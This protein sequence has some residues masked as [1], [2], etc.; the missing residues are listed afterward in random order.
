MR[1]E[2]RSFVLD[3][4]NRAQGGRGR[5]RSFDAHRAL[6]AKIKAMASLRACEC[7]LLALNWHLA[8]IARRQTDVCFWRLSGHGPVALRCPLLTDAASQP[9][10]S[11]ASKGMRGMPPA[12]QQQKRLLLLLKRGG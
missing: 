6:K 8:D 3:R 9:T 10:G 2:R 7:R 12:H 4:S 1:G 5:G 11:N